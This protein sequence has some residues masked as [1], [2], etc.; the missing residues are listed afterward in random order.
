MNGKHPLHSKTIWLAIIISV[1]SVMQGFVFD[2]PL[3]KV[4]QAVL[5]IIISVAIVLLR[6]ETKE[7]LNGS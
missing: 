2:F 5:G 7:P 4:W 3:D 6:Y 1:L